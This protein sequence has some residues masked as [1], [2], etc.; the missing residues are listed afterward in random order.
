MEP[1][2]VKNSLGNFISNPGLQHLAEY[3]FSCLNYKDL[4]SCQLINRS[5]G[6]ILANPKFWLIKFIQKGMSKKNQNDWI[7]AIQLTKDTDLARNIQLYLK[8]SLWKAKIVDIPCYIDEAIL[9]KSLE[10]IKEFGNEA[11]STLYRKQD[12]N[13]IHN[14]EN[15]TAGCIQT[16]AA[17]QMEK[18]EI[19]TNDQCWTL[20]N[21]LAAKDGNFEMVKTISPL[22]DNP[23]ARIPK[24]GATFT[25]ISGASK[26]GHLEIVKF[27]VPLSNNLDAKALQEIISN[28]RKG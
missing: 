24:Y 8:R 19:I 20:L 2:I 6:S 9:E 3:I 23:N 1:E 7:K 15:H 27:L 22:M 28:S 25:P 4:E 14:F 21:W 5:S 13:F 11:F 18:W 12:F 16:L 10:F 26:N 17:I